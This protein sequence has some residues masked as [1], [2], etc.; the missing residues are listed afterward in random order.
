MSEPIREQISAL[1]DGELADTEMG[2]LV[3]RL[4]RDAELRAAF[5]RYALLGEVVRN[6]GDRFA[7]AGFAQRVN[8][9]IDAVEPPTR[10]AESVADPMVDP[11]AGAARRRL[12]PATIGAVAAGVGVLA[13]ALVMVREPGP[14][15]LVAA[16]PP[17]QPS[18]QVPA[19]PEPVQV[20]VADALVGVDDSLTP[21]MIAHAQFVAPVARRNVLTNVIANDP[22]I[23]PED[24]PPVASEAVLQSAP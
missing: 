15:A 5:G 11:L 21:Y 3:R 18:P 22:G 16:N 24:A 7:S 8:A 13:V 6:S 2:L 23:S 4:E 12:G 1:L 17:T 14:A 19:R 20:G 9:A 10:A